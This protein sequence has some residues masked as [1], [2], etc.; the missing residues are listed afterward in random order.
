MGGYRFMTRLSTLQK[1][2][3][4]ML[5]AMFSGRHKLDKDNDGY[6]FIDSNGTYFHYILDYLRHDQ[7][8]PTEATE[9][10]YKEAMYYNLH[11]LVESLQ[12]TSAIAQTMV[13][14]MHR[15]QFPDYKELK[16]K[17]IRIGMDNA[18]VSKH[19][20]V[21]IYVFR[22]PFVPRANSFNVNHDCVADT[23]HVSVGPWEAV[24]DEDMLIRCLETDLIDEGFHIRPHEQRKRC[25]YYSGQ[26][27]QKVVYKITFLFQQ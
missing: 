7:L 9:A 20:D 22:K 2:P 19:G 15:A 4:S 27:C 25:K 11:A 1:Y 14:D 18:S 12:T 26:N 10:V 17:V 23:A 6:Y 16:K 8:P 21:I 13:K 24:A 5:A 3:D